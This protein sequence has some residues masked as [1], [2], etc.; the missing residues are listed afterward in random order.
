LIF[1]IAF[2]ELYPSSS[3]PA[4]TLASSSDNPST[5]ASA[6]F[7]ALVLPLDPDAAAGAVASFEA[8]IPPEVT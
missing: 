7:W 1:Y 2:L 4:G 6:S 5:A 8:A 3:P